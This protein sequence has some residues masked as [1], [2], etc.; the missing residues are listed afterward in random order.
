MKQRLAEFLQDSNKQLSSK[1]L[2]GLSAALTFI[3]LAILG[4]SIMLIS[5]NYQDF[6]RLLDSV[7]VFALTILGVGVFEY[8]YKTNNKAIKNVDN[9]Q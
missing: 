2:A 8:N 7:G 4:G 5:R 1:R 9:T 3:L 6:I